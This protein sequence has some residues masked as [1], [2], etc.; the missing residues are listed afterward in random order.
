M[1]ERVVFDSNIYLSAILSRGL[2]AALLRRAFD[3]DFRVVTSTLILNEVERKLRHKFHR[4]EDIIQGV[5]RNLRKLT[6]L[7]EPME[8]IQI[9]RDPKD[10]HI[11]AC[12]IAGNV[13]AIVTGD[14]DLL[15]LQTFRGIRILSPRQFMDE[16]P[17]DETVGR[18]P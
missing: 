6:Q 3:G 13:D 2:L 8:L 14:K 5:L 4:S 16:L 10:D 15:V 7:V 9:C 17:P 18:L 12:A 11:L 1:T